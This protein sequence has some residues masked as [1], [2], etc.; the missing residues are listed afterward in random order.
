MSTKKSSKKQGMFTTG[1]WIALACVIPAAV[2]T[3]NL[4]RSWSTKR[5]AIAAKQNDVNA[6][7]AR[8]TVLEPIYDILANRKFQICNK[9][10]LQVTVPWFAVAFHD[11]K[12]VKMFDSGRCREFQ[13][14]IIPTGDNKVVTLSSKQEGCNWNGSVMYYAMRLYR[15]VE[16]EDAVVDRPYDYMEVYKG[17]E[18]DCFTLQ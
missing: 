6:M 10:P 8:N 15:Q 14:I 7:M 16:T 3:W 11:G 17:Y 18:R 13:P 12:S 4:Y 9:T 5:T 2:L 1:S